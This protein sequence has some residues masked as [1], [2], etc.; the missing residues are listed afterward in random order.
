MRIVRGI[1]A[2]VSFEFFRNNK[3][4]GTVSTIY[5]SK[6]QF[7]AK[8]ELQNWRKGV[9]PGMT[10]DVVFEIDR[11]AK[12]TLSLLMLSSMVILKLKETEKKL[13]SL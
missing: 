1:K 2:E 7:V 11:K 8:I 10:A 6:N 12:V 13:K 5:P 9:L 4:F 3:L